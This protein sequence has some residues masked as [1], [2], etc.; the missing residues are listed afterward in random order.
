MASSS[1]DSAKTVLKYLDSHS[2]AT[3]KDADVVYHYLS[4]DQYSG[5]IVVSWVGTDIEITAIKIDD[6]KTGETI[7]LKIPNDY[8]PVLRTR[9]LGYVYFTAVIPVDDKVH[10]N[11][12]SI[13]QSK[14]EFTITNEPT[15][16]P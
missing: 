5:R 9:Q 7:I 16:Q 2:P 8:I 11:I 3:L 6:E 12:K 13:E 4:E 1:I 14:D 15:H 10:E